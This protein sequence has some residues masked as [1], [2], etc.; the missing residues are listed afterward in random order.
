MAIQ[1][2]ISD[3]ATEFESLYKREMVDKSYFNSWKYVQ[4]PNAT[5][6][7]RV[8]GAIVKSVLPSYSS[9]DIDVS[10][11][12]NKSVFMKPDLVFYDVNDKNEI[13]LIVDYES[14]NSSD[15]RVISKDFEP[16]KKFRIESGN[17]I[18]Y[19]VITTLPSDENVQSWPIRTTTNKSHLQ[20]IDEIKKD[21]RKY[22][23][24]V[25]RDWWKNQSSNK[26]LNNFW[27]FNI[28]S[29]TIESVIPNNKK[30]TLKLW[31]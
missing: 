26:K 22:W 19:V 5:C 13:K 31:N 17:Q 20:N 7:S 23:S 6:H 24:K 25:Y 11:V 16:F 15:Y 14:P 30:I 28:N 12:H 3:M 8:I 21:P 2:L 29:N 4:S 10:L 9:V 1:E 18:P 27:L